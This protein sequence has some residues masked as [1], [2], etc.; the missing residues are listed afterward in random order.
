[1]SKL[2]TCDSCGDTSSQAYDEETFKDEHGILHTFDLCAPC[3][4]KMVEAVKGSAFFS[5]LIKE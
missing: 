2:Y 3:R 1:M 4:V 5:K